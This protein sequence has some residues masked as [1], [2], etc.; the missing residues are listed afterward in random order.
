VAT[1]P[2]RR[3]TEKI[4]VRSSDLRPHAVT[5]GDQPLAGRRPQLDAVAPS[6]SGDERDD[7]DLDQLEPP[8]LRVA[9][10]M[11]TAVAP[12]SATITARSGSVAVAALMAQVIPSVGVTVSI[13][14]ARVSA[15]QGDVIRF[16]VDVRDARGQRITGLTPR[17]SFAPGNGSIDHDGSFVGN[18]PGKYVVTANLGARDAQAAVTLTGR[19]VRRTASVVGRLPRS[20]FY[21]S[22]VWLT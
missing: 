4:E 6:A 5:L 20:A 18:V 9:D 19:D 8:V 17:W 10:G 2:N 13:S 21:T 11:V 7:A 16:A 22:E 14:P 3:P 12:G 15:R 1:T